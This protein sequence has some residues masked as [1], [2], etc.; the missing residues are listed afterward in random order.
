MKRVKDVD[1]TVY[2]SFRS[3]CRA[4]QISDDLVRNRMQCGWTLE[5]ALAGKTVKQK[6]V[7]N[8]PCEDHLG[9]SYSSLA[10]MCRSYNIRQSL[11]VF[12]R[13]KG[14][15][16]EECLS[17]AKRT[18][19]IDP[20]GNEYPSFKA[21]CTAYRVGDK[22]TRDRLKRG[23]TLEEALGCKKIR[24]KGKACTDHKGN[25]Y[26][27]YTDMCKAYNI[28]LVTFM[29]RRARG[30][31][32]EDCLAQGREK[33]MDAD[34]IGYPDFKSMCRAHNL[35]HATVRQ[36]LKRGLSLEEALT[37]G[38]VRRI[39]RKS[40]YSYKG[41]VPCTDHKGN[42]YS[43]YV[44]MCRAYNVNPSTFTRRKARGCSIEECLAPKAE[45]NGYPNLK[46]MCRAR[47]VKYD[48]VRYRLKQGFSLKE[49]LT[50]GPV[51]KRGSFKDPGGNEYRSFRAMCAAH[52]VSYSTARDRLKRGL[53]LEKV[54][55]PRRRKIPKENRKE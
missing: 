23:W 37:D 2:P 47:N 48:T 19:A 14:W 43:S 8:T 39:A 50:D 6:R 1:G 3:L 26:D 34:G 4:H 22:V 17:P 16:L 38:P 53:P 45:E 55:V 41:A 42:S 44:E 52:N 9:N 33:V 30:W 46:A 40:N 51:S 7:A 35:E 49:A 29:N 13:N 24:K 12:R 15:T 5:E 10:E 25:T 27:S 11:F 18:P 21:M 54:L 36:R 20:Y 28:E 31:S 32:L